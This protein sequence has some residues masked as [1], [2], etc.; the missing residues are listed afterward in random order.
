[1]KEKIIEQAREI[2]DFLKNEHD[3]Q[4]NP[5]DVKL[6]IIKPF[7]GVSEI[8]LI[9]IGQDPT[10]KNGTERNKIIC[11][12]NL[13]KRNSL[14][15]YIQGICIG[16]GISIENVYATNLFK[17]FY[18]I[19][20]AKT[21]DVLEQHLKPNLDLL[22]KEIS[23]FKDTPIITLGQPVLMLL[24]GSK[25]KVREYWGYE[26]LI[27]NGI[28]RFEFSTAEQNFLKKDFYPFPH[29]PSIRKEFYKNTLDEY[30]KF[31]NLGTKK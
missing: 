18:S 25:A 10:I 24:S 20:P 17:Y 13:D 29:Q 31:V 22:K 9:I 27:K 21:I 14:Y 12:L 26:S 5:I 7:I 11:T 19:P 6:P 8:K 16:L 15:T 2:R 23:K 4:T 1:M 3:F 28:K 30:I